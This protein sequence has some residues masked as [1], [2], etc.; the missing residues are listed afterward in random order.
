MEQDKSSDIELISRAQAGDIEAR[1]ALILRHE[2][3]VWMMVREALGQRRR[4]LADEHFAS[5][6]D[7]LMRAIR[8]FDPAKAGSLLTYAGVSIKRAVWS[9]ISTDTPVTRTKN[10]P[11]GAADK[12]LWDRAS[13]AGEIPFG[14]GGCDRTPPVDQTVDQADKVAL[15]SKYVA[16][17]STLEQ[18]V[19]HLLYNVGMPLEQVGKEIGGLSRARVQQ[20]EASAIRRMRARGIA[21]GETTVS[22]GTKGEP[23]ER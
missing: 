22:P 15:L 3:F 14:T 7:G 2:R 23:R 5:G 13:S 21:D 18:A 19:L 10:K 9:G 6:L 16:G 12:A 1:N 8:S 4:H 17:L 11:T 20:I